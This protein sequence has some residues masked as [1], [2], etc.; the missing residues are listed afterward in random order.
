HR[1]RS[2][3]VDVEHHDGCDFVSDSCGNTRRQVWAY[4]YALVLLHFDRG[5]SASVSQGSSVCRPGDLSLLGR[6]MLWGLLSS[7]AFDL[8][9]TLARLRSIQGKCLVLGDQ[10]YW[11][12]GWSRCGGQRDGSFW[13]RITLPCRRV[14]G[15]RS[16][17]IVDRSG[18]HTTRRTDDR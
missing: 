12:S 15:V 13:K 10:L 11:K 2:G 1:I 14:C 4:K 18:G 16:A 9:R 5:S 6:S 17:R 3:L 8:G 7:W